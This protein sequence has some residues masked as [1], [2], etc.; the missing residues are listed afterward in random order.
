[1]GADRAGHEARRRGAGG[2]AMSDR[3][4]S[5]H[6]RESGDDLAA[7]WF[8]RQRAGDMTAAEAAELETWLDADPEHRAALDALARA[9]ERAELARH[10]PEILAWRER[11]L[12]KSGWRR[13][14]GGRAIAA[15][16]VVAVL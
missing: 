12:R 16:L 14:L 8:A 1:G 7:A 11:A 9:W 15:V 2:A 4:H 5:D 6:P 10:D 13:R 3:F